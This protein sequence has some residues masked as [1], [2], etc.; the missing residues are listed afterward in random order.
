MGRTVTIWFKN[1]K[2]S[3]VSGARSAKEQRDA[4]AF[5]AAFVSE[6]ELEP[7]KAGDAPMALDPHGT[8]PEAPCG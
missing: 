4:A 3:K 7:S 6:L 5:G 8:E 2:V 1:N